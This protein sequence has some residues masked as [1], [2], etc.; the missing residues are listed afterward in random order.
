MAAITTSIRGI[1]LSETASIPE[2]DVTIIVVP[3][4]A[5]VPSLINRQVDIVPIASFDRVI[6]DQRYSGQ[7]RKLFDYDDVLKAAT[8][9]VNNNTLLLVMA[10]K[11]IAKQRNVAIKFM[12]GYIRAIRSTNADPREGCC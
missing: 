3:V 12:K 4:P 2:K 9:N 10:D 1:G 5:M 7:T 11:L 8:G 6:L